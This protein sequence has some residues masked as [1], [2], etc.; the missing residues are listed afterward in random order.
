MLTAL[1]IDVKERTLKCFEKIGIL[2]D[3]TSL[4]IM[5]YIGDS[6]SFIASVIE[7]EDEFQIRFPN[8]MLNYE[9]FG[10]FDNLV[11]LIQN[12]IEENQ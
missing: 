2:I 12:L 9:V 4:E 5:E 6:V 1:T 8:D 10:T 11:N 3:D 7:L